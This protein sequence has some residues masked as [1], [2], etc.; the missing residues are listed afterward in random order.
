MDQQPTEH[1]TRT[2][3]AGI[4]IL[5]LLSLLWGGYQ[6]RIGGTLKK[7][8]EVLTKRT[9]SLKVVRDNLQKELE[10]ISSQL[11]AA[12]AQNQSMSASLTSI[13]EKLAEKD[14]ALNRLQKDNQSIGTLRKQVNELK[15]LKES[16]SNELASVKQE[17]A[18][19]RADNSRLT[20]ENADLRRLNSDK[21]VNTFLPKE[22]E[23]SSAS[24]LGANAFR[25]DVMNR[26][27]KLIV[28]GR[29]AREVAIMFDLPEGAKGG[30]DEI[31]YLSVKDITQKPLKDS[32]AKQVNVNIKGVMNPVT[33][34][35]T[36]AVDFTRNPQRVNLKYK[37]DEKLKAGVYV[38][39]L[40]TEKLFVGKVEFRL[41]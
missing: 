1:Q 12:T 17:N 38:A 11:E 37:L 25:V 24:L 23:E 9:D 41:R 16:L 36:K 34:H 40:F 18:R 20:Q 4:S 39:E 19:L 8:N 2:Y 31:V 28:K 33:V 7:E 14:K 29:R 3:A 15:N 32:K 35:L 30:E 22:E 26:K 13:N 27:E 5:L 6:W 10:G 21:N